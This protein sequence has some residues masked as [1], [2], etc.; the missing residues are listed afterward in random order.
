MQKKGITLTGGDGGREGG[1]AQKSISGGAG[2]VTKKARNP[3]SSEHCD[4]PRVSAEIR[5][6][7]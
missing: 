6:D 5:L 3:N 2:N 4:L 7:Y 1:R